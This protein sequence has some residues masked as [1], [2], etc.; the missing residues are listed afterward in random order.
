MKTKKL[1]TLASGVLLLIACAAGCTR[2]ADNNNPSGA[3]VSNSAA[4]PDVNTGS[5]AATTKSS[6]PAPLATPGTPPLPTTPANGR[7]LATAAGKPPERAIGSGGNDFFLFSK[8]RG[9][10][11]QD[12]QLKNTNIVVN[13]NGGMVTLTG[14]VANPEQK[15]RVEQLAHGVE[16]VKGIKNQLRVAAGNSKS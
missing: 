4:P 3:S 16:G 7:P 8:I 11:N 14:T 1:M 12:E 15:A 5:P 9:Q 2:I 6:S 10:I 13:I